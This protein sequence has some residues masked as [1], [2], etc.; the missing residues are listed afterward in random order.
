MLQLY[1]AIYQNLSIKWLPHYLKK[2]S[3]FETIFP[4]FIDFFSNRSRPSV[5]IYHSSHK[6]KNNKYE[7]THIDLE[8]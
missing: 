8:D 5:G 2:K 7:S 1:T 6:L 4:N 3:S